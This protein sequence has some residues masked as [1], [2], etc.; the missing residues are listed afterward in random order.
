M[1]SFE[2]NENHQIAGNINTH[3]NANDHGWQ[4][5]T[6]AKRQRKQKPAA[7]SAANNSIDNNEPNNV[8]RSLELQ[9]EDRRLK[10]IESQRVAANAVSVADTR[11][12]SKH[13]R[14]DGD[15]GDDYDSDEAGFLEENAKADEKK[16]KQKKPKK[17]KVTVAE[18]AAKI[19]AA[20]LANFLSDISGSYEGQQEIQL[21]RFADYFGRAFSAV[22]SSQF[23]WV[24]MF[25]E[26]TVA[27]LADIPLSHISEAVYKTSADWI[28]QRSIVALGSFVQWSL[29]SVLADLASQQGG[30][31]G[32]KKGV[33][34]ASS[35]SQV[36]MFVVLAM[37]LRRK[38]DALVNVLPTLR[39]S[40]N[41]QGQ[42][43]LVV[44]VWMIAQASH[45]DL[46]VGLYSWAHNLLPIM[47]GKNSNPQS[48]DIILQ[49]VEKILSAPKAKSILVSGAVRKG[50]RLM[51]PS[52][53]EILLRA[54]FPPSS[55][56]IKATERFGAIY[57]F[58]KEVALAGASG[59]KA[60]KQVSQQI[61][62]FALKA[63]GDSTPELSKEAAGISI[64]CLTENA[65]CYK[66][67]DEVYQDNLEASVAILKRLTEEWKGLSVKMAP[68]DPLRKTIENFRQ[69]NEKG[70]ETE[71]DAA[72]QALFRDADK[73]SKALSGKLSHGHG[74]LKGMAVVI[75]ALAAGAAVMSSNMESWDWKELPV[76]ISS[77]F[78]F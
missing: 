49:L 51:P 6:Y 8:F 19:D 26:N 7:H 36:A 71:A 42:D 73:Y 78:S 5:V 21:M 47:S 76:F 58:L 28:N 43:K 1:D 66:R 65:D 70:M 59:S 60:M 10:I 64:W 61:L 63:A 2:S 74:C 4:K 50:E 67:W 17:P 56:R 77:Q 11:S 33:Q 68:L 55:A 18:A 20:D 44:I 54:T 30:S 31:K 34:Q 41:Y 62:S 40:S 45:G 35:K 72:R 24:K 32:S 46:A 75:V 57:P 37:V 15:E 16:V 9:S 23:P 27:R 13:H 39:E 69:K 29:D 3:S 25:R 14:S 38:P 52:A 22:T 48:R 53:L 12:R